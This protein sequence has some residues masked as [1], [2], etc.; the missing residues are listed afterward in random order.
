MALI[1]PGQLALLL[2]AQL[3]A[4]RLLG[5]L[6]L[7]QH[8]RQLLA[9]KLWHV[10]VGLDCLAPE[11]FRH[12]CVRHHRLLIQEQ[13]K[14]RSGPVHTNEHTGEAFPKNAELLIRWS[15]RE[16]RKTAKTC[17]KKLAVR[18]FVVVDAMVLPNTPP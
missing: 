15:S 2:L 3:L 10:G 5:L 11:R 16:K 17:G 12:D 13:T 18:A 7:V 4:A 14:Y 6:Q 1:E 9:V 8:V